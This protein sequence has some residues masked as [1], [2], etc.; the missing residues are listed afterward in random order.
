MSLIT[1]SRKFEVHI[2][3]VK[4]SSRFNL[5]LGIQQVDN[6][7]LRMDQ[8]PVRTLL[9]TRGGSCARWRG[10][11]GQLAGCAPANNIAAVDAHAT[12]L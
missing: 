4:K 10:W 11:G 9:D 2:L 5:V 12:A 6:P 3:H 7:D 8:C 1:F